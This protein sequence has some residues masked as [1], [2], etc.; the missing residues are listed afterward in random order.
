MHTPCTITF[1]HVNRYT[2]LGTHM[3]THT[4]WPPGP[5]TSVPEPH[6]RVS[7][8][9]SEPWG[10]PVTQKLLL[11]GAWRRILP[12]DQKNPEQSLVLDKQGPT[13]EQSPRQLRVE[14]GSLSQPRAL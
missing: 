11:L 8:K 13:H 3:H 10:R 9:I 6:L 7:S 12:L 14:A 2:E 5:R 1:T 4:L